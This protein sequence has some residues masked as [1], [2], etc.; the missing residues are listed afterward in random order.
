VKDTNLDVSIRVFK[1]VIKA[2]KKTVKVD[3][4]NLFNFTLKNNILEW[5]ENFVHDHPNC[6][7]EELE[8][9]FHKH[10]QTMKNDEKVSM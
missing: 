8:Q 6:T 3:I 2:Y 10:F 7:F 1:K 9:T 5:G 4:I